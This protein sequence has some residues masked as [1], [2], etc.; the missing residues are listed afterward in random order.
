M[1]RLEKVIQFNTQFGVKVYTSP[2]RDIFN[3]DPQTVERCSSL[4]I[5]EVKEL[6]DA[7]N[8]DDFIETIDAL[9]DID[10]VVHG[11]SSRIGYD[12]YSNKIIHHIESKEY[13]L[14][15]NIIG[16][17]ASIRNSKGTIMNMFTYH[18]HNV[19]MLLKNINCNT[20]QLLEYVIK[21]NYD[22][23]CKSLR[24]LIISIENMSTAFGVN[25]DAA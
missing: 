2:Q 8:A 10:Y 24:N 18:I 20:F 11:M 4:I 21:K 6:N 17:P 22:G 23:I 15:K 12:M 3:T 13:E 19:H 16:S 9:G 25:I 7:I 5:E 14:V 1:Q